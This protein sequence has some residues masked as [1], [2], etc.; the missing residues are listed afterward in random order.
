MIKNIIISLLIILTLSNVSYSAAKKG[1]IVDNYKAINN[2]NNKASLQRGA[3][4]FMNYC[5]GCHSLKYMRMSTLAEDLDIE[6]TVFAKNLIFAD[7]KIGETMT[8][9][10]KESDALIWFNAAPPDLSLTARSK[11]ADYIYAKLN[12][13]YEDDNTATGFN[14]LALPNTSMPNILAGLQGGQKV[15][16]D[17]NNTPIAL[18]VKSKGTYD[19]NEFKQMTNDITNFLVYVSEPAKLKRYSIGFWVLLFIFIFTIIAYYTKKEF[20]K[21]IH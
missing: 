13:Y 21:D 20:W 15:I 4:Y 8:I 16:L 6:E 9:A 11:G 17:S 1:G 7:K 3:K 5:S 18:E 14:N 2:I 12:T 19:E 10:M